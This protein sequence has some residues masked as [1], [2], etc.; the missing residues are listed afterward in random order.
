M[1][2]ELK[3]ENQNLKE[4]LKIALARNAQL[5]EQLKLNSKNSS[6]PPSSDHKKNTHNLPKNRGGGQKGHPPHLRKR[7]EEQEIQKTQLCSTNACPRCGSTHITST[8]IT[9]Q[10]VIPR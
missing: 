5:E 1:I 2:D 9:T 7:F 6:K 4:A 3:K 8:H 10:K